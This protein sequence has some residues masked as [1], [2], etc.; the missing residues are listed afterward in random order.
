MIDLFK[1]DD[2][3][4]KQDYLYTHIV[5]Q[6]HDTESFAQFMNYKKRKYT[7]TDKSS[8]LL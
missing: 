4:K 6:N 5:E 8:L 7:H 1:S 3:Q 2:R